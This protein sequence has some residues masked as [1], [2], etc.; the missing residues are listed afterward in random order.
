MIDLRCGDVFVSR[1]PWRIGRMINAVQRFWSLD[2]RSEFSHA[3]I[4]TSV[5][6]ATLEALATVSCGNLLRDYAGQRVMIARPHAPRDVK[7]LALVTIRAKHLGQIYPGWRL[8]FHLVPPL[9]RTISAGG[10]FLVCSELVAKYLYFAGVRDRPYTGINPDTLADEWREHR[11][12]NILFTGE[13][14]ERSTM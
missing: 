12:Y 7:K 11:G 1:N 2:G 5:D 8:L 10:M 14:P 4:I 13:L 9:A 6:G 3:G